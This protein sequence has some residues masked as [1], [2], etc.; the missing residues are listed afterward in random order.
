MSATVANDHLIENLSVRAEHNKEVLK[1]VGQLKRVDSQR[2]AA[3]LLTNFARGCEIILNVMGNEIVSNSRTQV[4]TAIANGLNSS[5][6]SNSSSYCNENRSDTLDSLDSI[7]QL[8][9]AHNLKAKLLFSLIMV[10][11]CESKVVICKNLSIKTEMCI[12]VDLANQNETTT[13]F[14]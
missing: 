7:P 6:G 8:K 4:V 11:M 9:H 2:P 12:K 13:L 14:T 3:G 10:S 1:C 5:N